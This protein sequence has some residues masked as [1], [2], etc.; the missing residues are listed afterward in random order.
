M[1]PAD[2]AI[3]KAIRDSKLIEEPRGWIV[4]LRDAETGLMYD[5]TKHQPYEE[6][7]RWME[8]WRRRTVAALLE[9]T[10]S[11]ATQ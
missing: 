9:N 1:T 10:E 11:E 4:Q 8:Q 6:G 2:L 5:A 3:A 7:R